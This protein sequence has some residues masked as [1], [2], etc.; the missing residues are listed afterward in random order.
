MKHKECLG[1]FPKI[2]ETQEMYRGIF[3]IHGKVVEHK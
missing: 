3:E 2:Y 1:K